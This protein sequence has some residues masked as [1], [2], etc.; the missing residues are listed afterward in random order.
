M[1]APQAQPEPNAR[2][3]FKE[4]VR[5]NPCIYGCPP[6]ERAANA[7]WLCKALT[8]NNTLNSAPFQAKAPCTLSAGIPEKEG[9]YHSLTLPTL[10]VMSSL[11]SLSSISR[12]TRLG[13]GIPRNQWTG[14]ASTVS[15]YWP[16]ASIA[17]YGPHMV[18]IASCGTGLMIHLP[19]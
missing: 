8:T 7:V 16:Y 5:K 11:S 13:P 9:K 3:S 6:P 17:M 4:T 14:Y 2:S 12:W 10:P 18:L 1:S 19:A 15:Y